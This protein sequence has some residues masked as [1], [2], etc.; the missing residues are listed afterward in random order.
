MNARTP[1]LAMFLVATADVTAAQTACARPSSGSA[2]LLY[3]EQVAAKP[4]DTVVVARLCL[5]AGRKGL[6]SYMATMTYDTATM[7]AA[8]V[9]TSGGMQVANS[10][11]AGLI[12]IAGAAPGGFP[13]G[14]LASIS[15]VPSRPQTLE[16]LTLSIGEANTPAGVSIL[17]ETRATG[18]RIKPAVISRPRVDSISPRT[19]EVSRERVTDLV[20]YGRGFLAAGNTIVFGGAEIPG[21]SSERGGTVIRFAAPTEFPARGAVPTRRITAGRIEVRIRHSGG[22]SNAVIFVARDDQ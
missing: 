8:S 1:I 3:V 21:L 16:A 9:Q 6:G 17:S 18:W 22:A 7:R 15:F 10:R 4:R 20:L 12:R 14:L 13:N 19:A 11:I 5:A 2:A